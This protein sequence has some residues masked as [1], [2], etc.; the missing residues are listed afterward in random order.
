MY[1]AGEMV[2]RLGEGSVLGEGESYAAPR[3]GSSK[4]PVTPVP[5]RTDASSLLRQLHSNAHNTNTL[6]YII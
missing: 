6:G 3:S 4:L 2:Q 5:R 1:G